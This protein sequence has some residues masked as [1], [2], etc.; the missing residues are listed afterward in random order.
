MWLVYRA[1][2]RDGNRVLDPDR[3][4]SGAR[5]PLLRCLEEEAG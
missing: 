5:S 1:T 3:R 4:E 2:A